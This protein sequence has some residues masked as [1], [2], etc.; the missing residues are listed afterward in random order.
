[1]R[2]RMLRGGRVPRR[3]T[4]HARV[5]VPSATRAPLARVCLTPTL[6]RPRVLSTR[7]PPT[8]ALAGKYVRRGNQDLRD[9]IE[10]QK[11]TRKCYCCLMVVAI[12]VVICLVA[13]LGGVFGTGLVKTG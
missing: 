11:K 13:G 8:P 2:G 1:M 9:A 6:P 7:R 12:I 3:P 10:N 5:R 4:A